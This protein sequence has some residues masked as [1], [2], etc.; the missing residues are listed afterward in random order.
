ML[1]YLCRRA[2]AA[3]AIGAVEIGERVEKQYFVG[4]NISR[5]AFI[6]SHFF[7]VLFLSVSVWDNGC[8]TI[9]QGMPS[10]AEIC[11]Q[12]SGRDWSG[13]VQRKTVITTQVQRKE[14]ALGGLPV[15]LNCRGVDACVR[16]L[17]NRGGRGPS[18]PRPLEEA[19]N[20]QPVGWPPVLPVRMMSP[21]A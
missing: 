7:T 15:D 18:S 8:A 20:L 3:A 19:R 14:A 6:T 11:G 2:C 1:A 9:E 12:C 10:L 4:I 17:V 13:A 21:P 5:A 16:T